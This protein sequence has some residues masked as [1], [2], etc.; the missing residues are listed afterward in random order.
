[1]STFVVA[2]NI[3]II[4]VNYSVHWMSWRLVY[5]IVNVELS[6]ITVTLIYNFF[7]Q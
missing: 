6:E 7:F 5:Y 4:V 2:I 1:M 3:C